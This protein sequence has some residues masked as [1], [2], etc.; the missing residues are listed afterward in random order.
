M[1][2]FKCAPFGAWNVERE[3]ENGKLFPPSTFHLPP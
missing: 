1:L 3:I 2:S